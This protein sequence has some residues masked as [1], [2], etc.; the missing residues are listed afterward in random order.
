MHTS[1]RHSMAGVCM[2]EGALD[3]LLSLFGSQFLHLE[4]ENVNLYR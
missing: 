3:K 1:S 2:L 4:N